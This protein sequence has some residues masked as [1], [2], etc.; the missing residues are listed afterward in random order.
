MRDI[1]E[2]GLSLAILD[3]IMPMNAV[4]GSTGKILHAGPTLQKM[5]PEKP[6]N[7]DQFFEAFEVRRPRGATKYNDLAQTAETRLNLRLREIPGVPLKGMAM[8]LPNGAGVLVNL[9]FGIAAVD[10]VG[11]FDLSAGDFAPTD[12]TTEMLYLAEAKEAVLEESRNL[13]M[14][15]KGAKN[16]AEEQAFTDTLTGLKNRRAMDMILQRYQKCGE[17]FGMMHLDLDYFKEVNDTLGHA[18]GDFVLQKAATIFVDETRDADTVVRLGGDEFVLLFHRL[19]DRTLLGGVANRI[20]RHLQEPMMFQDT[21]CQ[22]SASIGITISDDY[23]LVEPEQMLIDADMALYASK[24]AGRAQYSFVRDVGGVGQS[25]E[26]VAA[27]APAGRGDPEETQ[28]D[29]A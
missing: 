19:T 27:A 21:A 5:R 3:R 25:A 15:L 12:L 22:I 9:S 17:K 13:N 16:A 11:I 23:L 26:D 2:I 4:I 8:P 24:N 10:A 20:L 28:G 6:M 29:A 18:A 1:S 14:R 7:G